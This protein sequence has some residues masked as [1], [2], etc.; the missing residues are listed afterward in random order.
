MFTFSQGFE[1]ATLKI[2]NK[3][4][5]SYNTSAPSSNLTNAGRNGAYQLGY[6]YGTGANDP[7]NL[8]TVNQGGVIVDGRDGTTSSWPAAPD[9]DPTGMGL[10]GSNANNNAQ[11]GNVPPR[12]Q[13]I[14]FAKF[15]TRTDALV[16]RDIL[17][18]RRVDIEKGAV[19]KAEMAKKNLHTKRGVGPLGPLSNANSNVN[20]NV[21]GVG[22][23]VSSGMGGLN[24]VNG[25]IGPGMIG[26]SENAGMSGLSMLNSGATG[27]RGLSMQEREMGAIG[28][29][30]LGVH[31]SRRDRERL[32]SQ[33]QLEE[34]LEVR[35]RRELGS[36]SLGAFGNA[37]ALGGI[38]T[39][40]GARERLEEDERERER[41]RKEKEVERTVRLRAGSAAMFES[42]QPSASVTMPLRN[43]SIAGTGLLS[44]TSENNAN[45]FPFS[46][47][48]QP[49][50]PQEYGGGADVWSNVPGAAGSVSRSKLAG[51][52][53]NGSL[54]TPVGVPTSSSNNSSA[55]PT[56]PPSSHQ[57]SPSDVNAS[58]VTFTQPLGREGLAISKD[59]CPSA[60]GV[61]PQ[62]LHSQSSI[63][64]VGSRSRPYSPANEQSQIQM[65][66]GQPPTLS[67]QTQVQQHQQSIQPMSAGVGVGA[68]A[69]QSASSAGMSASRSSSSSSSYDGDM[70]RAMGN[71]EISSQQGT[72]SPQLPSPNSA[73]ASS[74]TRGTGSD[75]NP[76]VC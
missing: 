2:P 1:A 27:T 56:R 20:N 59:T 75:Q 53:I 32:E 43:A 71:M 13:I 65:Q 62:S 7:Y 63:S 61:E 9:G 66:Q 22:M 67:L 14:G 52:G 31:A 5:T 38:F 58:E 23:G 28:A 68:V 17:Q 37:N 60:E 47:T 44:P 10:M 51:L 40:R 29:M 48:A 24:D 21:G 16:A 70:A 74:G 35:K 3:D 54:R 36:T 19:L 55:Q 45:S 72:I 8:V 12:K 6:P 46:A 11:Q 50:T 18:G 30:G 25:G 15:K 26:L 33:Q 49:F 64:S 76:P 69:I 73:G 57:S 34:E 4:S 42:Y 41:R 39:T